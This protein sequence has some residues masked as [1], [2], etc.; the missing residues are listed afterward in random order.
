M[1]DQYGQV[2]NRAIRP[3]A[4]NKMA[5]KS[6]PD[7]GRDLIGRCN[8]HSPRCRLNGTGTSRRH[9]HM[10][11]G[12]LNLVDAVINNL[13]GLHCALRL[14]ATCQSQNENG[15]N[16]NQSYF[17]KTIREPPNKLSSAARRFGNRTLL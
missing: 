8:E 2:N 7:F 15:G 1:P 9:W 6:D 16:N 11:S 12:K 5:A 17:H 3:P 14:R 4:W 13:Y 10:L